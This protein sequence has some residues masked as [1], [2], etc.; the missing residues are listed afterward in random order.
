MT[1]PAPGWFDDPQDTYFE[2][3]WDGSAWTEHARPKGSW[4]QSSHFQASIDWS[5]SATSPTQPAQVY[6]PSWYTDPQDPS[7]QRWW[8][9]GAWTERV[10]PNP[11][12]LPQGSTNY[13]TGQSQYAPTGMSNQTRTAQA[14]SS[15]TYRPNLPS[16][17]GPYTAPPASSGNKKKL[18]L[19]V[20]A[21]VLGLL[22]VIIV[23]VSLFS[24]STTGNESSVSTELGS[25]A[26]NVPLTDSSQDAL[27]G[28][29]VEVGP[30]GLK[31]LVAASV[32]SEISS[33]CSSF[34]TA[35]T[36]VQSDADMLAKNP[37]LDNYDKYLISL[38]SV[39]STYATTLASIGFLQGEDYNGTSI[40][41][42]FSEREATQVRMEKY[43][44]DIAAARIP[45][46]N[47]ATQKQVDSAL[48]KLGYKNYEGFGK[49][50]TE[51]LDDLVA[52]MGSDAVGMQYVAASLE[53][54]MSLYE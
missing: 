1:T 16:S 6:P 12:S 30:E 11:Q 35:L 46:Q 5:Q 23:A 29:M 8:D 2:R 53:G 28:E 48:R 10:Q 42:S 18:A 43:A 44:S 40:T 37:T 25:D 51:M 15:Q 39:F 3:W 19:S 22:F 41:Y 54:C 21:A 32:V 17:M 20:S 14:Q 24:P 52:S 27:P 7:M 45:I 49:Y 50:L 38:E 31:F 36:Q 33:N 47:A 9:G 4:E 26:G 34:D 13:A